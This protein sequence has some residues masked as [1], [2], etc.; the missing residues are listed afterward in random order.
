MKVEIETKPGSVSTLQIELHLPDLVEKEG[1][2]VGHR[3]TPLPPAHG[4]GEGAALD[5]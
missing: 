5:Y 4:P 3:E 2:A 1:A